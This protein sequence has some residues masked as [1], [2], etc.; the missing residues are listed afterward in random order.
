MNEELKSKFK[1][2]MVPDEVA[3]GQLIDEATKE[4][5]LS[6]YATKEEIPVVPDVSNFI[7]LEDIPETDL[8]EYAKV[9][10]IPSLDGLLNQTAAE[11]LY[12]RKDALPNFEEYAKKTDIPAPQDLSHLATKEEIPDVSGFITL[13]D[14]PPTDLSEYAKVADIPSLDGL[15]SENTAAELYV[16]KDNLDTILADYAKKSEI[17]DVS[18]FITLN[19]VPEVDLSDYVKLNDISDLNNYSP[20]ELARIRGYVDYESFGTVGD[21]IND[22][23]VQIKAAHNYAN[24]HSLPVK[25]SSGNYYIKDTSQIIIQT[26]TNFGES[27]IHIDESLRGSSQV[28]EITSKNEGRE[29]SQSEIDILK[30]K[31]IKNSYAVSELSKYRDSLL[32]V[33]NTNEN[34]MLRYGKTTPITQQDVIYINERG[35]LGSDIVETF[36]DITSIKLIP[37]DNSY[38]VVEGGHFIVSGD[39]KLPENGIYIG[40]VFGVSRSRV[41]AKNQVFSLPDGAR[42]SALSASHGFYVLDSC[43]DITLEN[44][45]MFPREKSRVEGDVLPQVPAGTYGIGGTYCIGLKLYNVSAENDITGWGVMGMNY[46]KELIVRDSSLNRIDVHYAGNNI[47]IKDSVIGSF[48][49]SINGSGYIRIKDTIFHSNRFIAF[50]SDYGAHW[51][52]DITID[53]C[54][55]K[56][57][58]ADREIV[59]LNFDLREFDYLTD[60]VHGRNI[61]LS[62]IKLDFSAMPENTRRA[63][64]IKFNEVQQPGGRK[65]YFPQNILLE[66]I[67]VIGREKGVSLLEVFA[68]DKYYLPTKYSIVDDYINTNATFTA[69]NCDV[70]NEEISTVNTQELSS[71]WVFQQMLEAT[72]D[73]HGWAPEMLFEN[74]KGLDLQ[75]KYLPANI[76]VNNCEVR[77]VD[78][79]EGG[80]SPTKSTYNNCKFMARYYIDGNFRPYYFV[81]ND[82]FLPIFNNCEFTAPQNESGY[83]LPED[84]SI[85]PYGLTLSFRNQ[86]LRGGFIGCR[87][88][89]ASLKFLQEEALVNTDNLSAKLLGTIS[90]VD[91]SFE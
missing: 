83:L 36:N 32:I 26:Y 72:G 12:V 1:N 2:G 4:T 11:T 88:P 24:E 16:R 27:R 67:R 7:T 21:G 8:S 25:V 19:E 58:Q 80:A 45:R 48:G 81:N 10:D 77:Q 35:R 66:N 65:A 85:D 50:R 34:R 28:F 30:G 42:D 40:G 59:F 57:I 46:L 73:N 37:C 20:E 54:T 60:V 56:P 41:V 43:Y 31:I 84:L 69:R 87:M 14:I 23:G 15:L 76:T 75:T 22:D 64:A 90:S 63:L 51:D 82:N 74:I 13:E 47:T 86:T 9:S 17:P 39:G 55:I 44:I 18:E 70:V 62:N 29:L 78:N 6:G 61:K 89:H 68:P 3:F 52:G 53:D 49:V 79:Y 5:D 33:K 38:L 91:V 71:I